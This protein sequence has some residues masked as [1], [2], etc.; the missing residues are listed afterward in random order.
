MSGIAGVISLKGPDPELAGAAFRMSWKLA[1]SGKDNEGFL[2]LNEEK[3]SLAAGSST[4]EKVLAFRNHPVFLDESYREPLRF[5][6]VHRLNYTGGELTDFVQPVSDRSGKIWVILAGEIYNREEMIALAGSAAIKDEK[7]PSD[8]KILA[9]GWLEK[10]P[11]FLHSINGQY[12]AAIYDAR[13]GYIFLAR[14]RHGAKSLFTPCR[15]TG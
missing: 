12:A 5:A 6:W 10:G 1:P 2:I 13:D 3:V 8:A 14:D 9:E 7:T 15:M 4:H 11:E